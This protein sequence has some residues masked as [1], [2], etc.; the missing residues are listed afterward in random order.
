MARRGPAKPFIDTITRLE[1]CVRLMDFP[2]G[3][4][5]EAEARIQLL[6]PCAHIAVTHGFAI[7]SPEAEKLGLAIGERRMK[8]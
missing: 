8:P 5:E 4:N 1:R 6:E 7:I 2:P 3:P